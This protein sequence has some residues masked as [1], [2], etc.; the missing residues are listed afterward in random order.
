MF[1]FEY[2]SF[3]ML[4]WSLPVLLLLWVA[5]RQW[6]RR[7]AARLGDPA[8]ME[9]LL[10]RQA[11]GE[12]W[13]RRGLVLTAVA[14]LVVA[15]ANPQR[16]AKQ[17]QVKQESADVIIA[18][19]ISQSMYCADVAP[20]RLERARIFAQ[21]LVK[22]LEGERIGLIFFAGSAYLQMPL[23]TDYEAA[24]M[25]LRSAAPDMVSEQGTALATAIQLARESFDPNSKAGRALILITDGEDHD[26]GA[27][28]A[29]ESAYDDGIVVFALGAGTTQGGPIPIGGR[30]YK[31]DEDGGLI[32]SK[33][34]ASLLQALAAAGGGSAYTISQGDA[35]IR[36]ID[37][38]VDTM[39]KRTLAVR[40]YS[41]FESYFQWLSAPAIV[42]LLVAQLPFKRSR[43]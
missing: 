28:T 18:L 6:R 16:G 35:A 20:N 4:L 29:A 36:A 5:Y 3:L 14:L 24:E 37:A 42:L 21:K 38:A 1:R 11:P 34:N 7:A 25:F 39:E 17:Q 23:S 40:S 43:N 33:L 22:A 12:F 13:V 27:E 32:R 31:T 26:A 9:R 30:Q 2:P 41:D 8:L 19:D 15:A 10:P